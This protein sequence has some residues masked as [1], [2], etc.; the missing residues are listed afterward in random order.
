MSKLISLLLAV[1]LLS[2]CTAWYAAKETIAKEGANAADQ[3]LIVF[4]WGICKQ[5]TIGS[6]DRTFD[7]P[8]R[9][10]TRSD[11]CAIFYP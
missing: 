8:E 3:E 11:F 9:V 7:T 5:A 2:G 10:A 4:A 1:V 6:I